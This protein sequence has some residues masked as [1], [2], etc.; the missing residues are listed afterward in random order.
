[1]HAIGHIKKQGTKPLVEISRDGKRTVL[2]AAGWEHFG[3]L[4]CKP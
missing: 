1:M 2:A 4:D 3:S